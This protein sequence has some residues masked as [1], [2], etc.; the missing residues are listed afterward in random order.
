MVGNTIHLTG[1]GLSRTDAT[2]LYVPLQFWFC[3]NPGLALPLI[4]LQYHEVKINLE[5]RPK[6]ECYVTGPASKFCMC[7]KQCQSNLESGYVFL[8][9]NMPLSSL[10]ISILIPM[11]DA[12]WLKLL[13]NT[14]LT[15]FNSLVT[16]LL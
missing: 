6:N 4:A 12:E 5:F 16:N 8:L 13:T 15:N 11:K 1:T 9:L 14:L 10:T 2:T 7:R 3:R